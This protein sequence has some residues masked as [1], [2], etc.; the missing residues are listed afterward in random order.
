MKK[1]VCLITVLLTALIFSFNVFAT[2]DIHN[3]PVTIV[4]Y[5]EDGSYIVEEIFQE[6]SLSRASNYKSGTK[7][8][9]YYNSDDE[10]QWTATLKG[11]F[12]YT[13]T[14]ATCVSSSISFTAHD[15]SWKCIDSSAT[16]SDSLAKGE[17]TVKKYVLGIPTKTIE[18]IILLRCS[19]TGTIT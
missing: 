1:I 12:T 17:F 14:S 16:K 4:E 8:Y 5:F 11:E 13:G 7:R 18:Q 19:A 9:N 15:S 2:T 3:K 10:L 6:S